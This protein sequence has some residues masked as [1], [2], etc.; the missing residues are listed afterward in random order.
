MKLCPFLVAGQS[1][2]APQQRTSATSPA[3]AFATPDVDA[4]LHDSSAK[5]D[6]FATDDDVVRDADRVVPVE[7]SKLTGTSEDLGIVHFHA[8]SFSTS[9]P[10]P[11]RGGRSAPIVGIECL[12]EVCRFFHAGGCRFDAL[13]DAQM[14]SAAAAPVVVGTI[15]EGSAASV[16]QGAGGVASS[17]GVLDE[18]WSLQRESLREVLGGFSKVS[19]Q[20]GNVSEQLGT[21]A[22]QVGKTHSQVSDAVT[23]VVQV[24]AN[25]G[26]VGTAVGK[27]DTRVGE[28]GGTVGQVGSQVGQVGTQV[29]Q[30][31]TQVAQVGSSVGRLESQVTKVESQVTSVGASVATVESQVKRVESQLTN[32]QT[33]VAVVSSEVHDL[34]AQLATMESHTRAP[35]ED[36]GAMSPELLDLVGRHF[37]SLGRDVRQLEITL[38]ASIGESVR[39]AVKE[40]QAVAQQTSSINET[41]MRSVLEGLQVSLRALV[42]ESQEALRSSVNDSQNQLGSL[43]A[44]ASTETRAQLERGLAK[45]LEE[46]GAV[47]DTR[48]QIQAALDGLTR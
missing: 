47:R 3:S 24:A 40:S 6:L 2:A 18:V 41:S 17:P 33:S 13:F 28:I 46:M 10:V 20:V 9:L 29:S 39:T 16:G 35:V 12:G 15:V 14:R 37:E 26:Q 30:V 22:T 11:L 4:V 8:P 34:R 38:R 23:H 25:V 27:V 43:L 44:R 31:G 32:V 42:Q 48:T 36:K 5:S 45:M 19:S 21:M 7:D 1:M